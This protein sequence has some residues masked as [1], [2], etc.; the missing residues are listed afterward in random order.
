MRA[1]AKCRGTLTALCLEINGEHE[2][3]TRS[4]SKRALISRRGKGEKKCPHQALRSVR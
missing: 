4:D 3:C 2:G 1:P